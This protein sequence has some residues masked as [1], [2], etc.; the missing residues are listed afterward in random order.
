MKSMMFCRLLDNDFDGAE[1]TAEEKVEPGSVCILEFIFTYG[2]PEGMA[3]GGC[4]PL[5]KIVRVPFTLVWS[6]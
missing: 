5:L 4:C 2:R 3:R 1:H 6:L